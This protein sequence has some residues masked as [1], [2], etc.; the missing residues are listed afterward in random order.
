MLKSS[1]RYIDRSARA[2]EGLK[3]AKIAC[4]VP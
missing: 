1:S 3:Y 4:R 2:P